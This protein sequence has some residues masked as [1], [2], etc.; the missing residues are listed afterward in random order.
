M[1][2]RLL[3]AIALAVLTAV[4]GSIVATSGATFT[5]ASSS[6]ASA[7]SAGVSDFLHLYS[8]ASPTGTDPD[9]LNGYYTQAGVTPTAMAATGSDATLSVN[10]GKEPSA[11]TNETRV[12]TVK[13]P[14]TFPA[15][16]TSI[17]VAIIDSV[18]P[19]N[20]I[21]GIGFANVGNS[22]RSASVTMAAGAKQ[23]VNIRTA[24]PGTSGTVYTATITITVTYSG[25]TGSMFTYSVPFRV[26]RA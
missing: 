15:G 16:V 6:T 5:A 2:R 20:V 14:S 10:L 26:T 1:K 22:G 11:N 9:G 8:Q 19:N 12:F 7:T 3:I 23:Q 21:N 17:T 18:D 13:A 4:A 24:V 25:Y